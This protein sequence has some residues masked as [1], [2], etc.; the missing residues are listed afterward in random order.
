M[1]LFL[2]TFGT[3]GDVLPFAHLAELLIA[4]GHAVTAHSWSQYTDAF[5]SGVRFVCAGDDVAAVDLDRAL[6][7]GLALSSPWDQVHHFAQTFYGLG[8]SDQRAAAYFSRCAEALSGHDLAVCN[9]LDHLGHAAAERAQIP[10]TVLT[11]RPPPPPQ[12]DAFLQRTD[13][14]LSALVERVTGRSQQVRTFRARSPLLNLVKVSPALLSEYTPEP[15]LRVTGSWKQPGGEG[16]LSAEVSA[17]VDAGPTLFIGFGTLPDI[18]GRTQALVKAAL[19]SG[20]RVLAQVPAASPDIA[21]DERLL[22]VRARVPHGSLFPRLAAVVHH[23]GCGTTHAI[24]RAGLP[25]VAMPHMADQFF[26]AQ[27]IANQ[28]AGPAPLSP[29]NDGPGQLERSLAALRSPGFA[30]RAKALGAVLRAERGAV[31]A[32]D[33]LEACVDAP[34]R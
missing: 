21:P 7:Q 8:A 31:I 15:G 24:L 18:R 1:R 26:W 12:A 30:S 25:S 19:N 34:T 22:V 28:G 10:W 20:W 23:G 2:S 17:F 6:A 3:E 9:V 14:A 32:A 13:R 27:A 16:A 5:P 11:S 4:R 33:A 29:V